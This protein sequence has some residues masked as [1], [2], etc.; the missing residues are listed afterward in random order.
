VKPGRYFVMITF[1]AALDGHK[2]AWQVPAVILEGSRP[3]CI[4]DG[5][6]LLLPAVKR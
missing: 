6:N 2:V 4:L 5:G 3:E 1:P